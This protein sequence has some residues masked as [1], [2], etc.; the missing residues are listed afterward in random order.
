MCLLFCVIFWWFTDKPVC[1]QNQKLTYGV[2]RNENTEIVCEVD[3]YP[4]PD[5]FKW[6]F[7]R[8][9]GVASEIGS[10]EVVQ[11]TRPGGS[12][13]GTGNG[14]NGGISSGKRGKLSSVLTY[15]PS[16][17]GMGASGNGHGGVGDNDFGTVTCR[18]SNTAGQQMEPCVFHV[19]AAGEYSTINNILLYPLS[20]NKLSMDVMRV[21]C[22]CTYVSKTYT[23]QHLLKLICFQSINMY[24]Y[25]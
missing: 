1:R 25:T 2:A 8:T 11:H 19:I 16:A 13:T 10:N 17:M 3:A 21:L 23:L 4:A 20:K 12:E 15:S 5:V 18:A 6:T 14:G 9:G 7:N 24:Y 22:V